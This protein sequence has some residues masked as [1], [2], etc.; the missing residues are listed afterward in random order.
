MDRLS[1]MTHYQR[2]S[3]GLVKFHLSE[4]HPYSCASQSEWGGER[5]SRLYIKPVEVVSVN[6]TDCLPLPIGNDGHLSS[7]PREYLGMLEYKTE[8]EDKLI[9]NLILGSET[10]NSECPLLHSLLPSW[11][12]AAASPSPGFFNLHTG[13]QVVVGGCAL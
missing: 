6:L 13:N 7:G 8:D 2:S 10:W 9:Q 11:V 12:G 5:Q 1:D 3:S 4:S